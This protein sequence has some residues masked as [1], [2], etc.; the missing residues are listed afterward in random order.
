MTGAVATRAAGGGSGAL[1]S[2][3]GEV[4]LLAEGTGAVLWRGCGIGEL[5]GAT[6]EVTE[7]AIGVE[8]VAARGTGWVF[9]AGT[10]DV[11]SFGWVTPAPGLARR[12]MRTVSFFNGTAAVFAEGVGG[13]VGCVLLSLMVNYF[14][15]K[16]QRVP[17]FK[18]TI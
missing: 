13:G 4:A 14:V 10:G 3:I 8:L 15:A 2:W 12:V 18:K 16:S 17:N 1:G 11:S 7:R 6:G 5:S 9:A